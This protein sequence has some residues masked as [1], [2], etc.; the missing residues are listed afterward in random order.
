MPPADAE[1]RKKLVIIYHDE[2]IFH[3][4]EGQTWI[5]GTGDQ[6]FIKPKTKGSGIMVSDFVE[7]HGGFLQLTEDEHLL[8]YNF[9]KRSPVINRKCTHKS[10]SSSYVL[11]LKY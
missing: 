11:F 5:W 7:Q 9:F 3:I 6:P 1:T 2:S 10:F 4:N 8:S